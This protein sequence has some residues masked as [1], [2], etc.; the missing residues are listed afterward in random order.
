MRPE[1]PSRVLGIRVRHIRAAAVL[2][3]LATFAALTFAP[4]PL[5]DTTFGGAGSGAGEMSRPEGIAVDRSNGRLYVADRNNRRVDV[6]NASGSFIMAFGWGVADGGSKLETCTTTCLAGLSGGGAGEFSEPSGIAVDNESTSSSYHDVYV[7]DR[8]RVQK[9]SPGGEFLLAFGG[10]VISAGAAGTGDL[11]SGS[12]EVTSVANTSHRFEAGQ[13]ITGTGIPASTTVVAVSAGELTL[14]RPATAS[15]TGATMTVAEGAGNVPVNERQTVNV[16]NPSGMG[17][18]FEA[19]STS[20]FIYENT[21]ASG[22]ASIQSELEGLSN[23]GPGNV[24]VTGPV[25]GPYSIEF[26]GALADTNVGQLTVYG[27]G[28]AGEET[29]VNGHSEPGVCAIAANCSAGVA[30]DGQPGSFAEE[31]PI[32]VAGAA[33]TVYVADSTPEATESQQ[34]YKAR[35]EE[36]ESDGDFLGQ[37]GPLSP[38]RLKNLAVAPSGDFYV[39]GLG[40]RGVQEY[41]ASGHLLAELGPGEQLTLDAAGNLYVNTSEEDFPAIAEFDSSGSTLTRFGY[42]VLGFPSGGLAAYHNAN[43]D[44][45]V[46]LN[47]QEPEVQQLALP[48][49]GP[50]T[51]LSKASSSG[52]LATTAVLHSYVNPEG[53]ATTY[54]FQYVDKHDFEAEGGFASAHT[55]STAESGP[56]GSDFVLHSVSTELTGLDPETVY[57]F[58][59]VAAN[60]AGLTEGTQASFET[61][62]PLVL[63][64]EWATEVSPE[65]AAVHAEVDPVGVDATG[66]FQYVDDATYKESGFADALAAPAV[67]EGATPLDFGSAITMTTAGT[68]LYPLQ[69]DTTYH[70][71]LVASDGFVTEFGPAQT[72]STPGPRA[73]GNEECPNQAL[74]IGPSA[75]LPDCRA[76]E[77]VSPV[78]KN[79]GDA[80]DVIDITGFRTRLDESA[81]SGDAFSYTSAR[82]FP[83]SVG[84]PYASQYLA[85]RDPS[86]GWSSQPISPAQS[87]PD[88]RCCYHDFDNEYQAFSPELTDG[89]FLLN[90]EPA[91]ASG[92]VE[93]SLDLYSRNNVTGGYGVVSTPEAGVSPVPVELALQGAEVQGTSSDGETT[94]FTTHEK[95]ATTGTRGLEQLYDYSGG[96]V[97][98]VCVLPSGSAITEPCSAG[99]PSSTGTGEDRENAVADALSTAGTRVYWTDIKG[100]PG[101][102]TLYLRENPSQPQSALSGSRCTE[103]EKA[104][105]VKVSETV[106][107]EPAEFWTASAD[108]SKALFTIGENLYEFDLASKQST[109]IARKALGVAGASEDLA[110]VYFVSTEALGTGAQAGQPNLYMHHES[111]PVKYIATLASRDVSHSGFDDVASAPIY[112]VSRVTPDGRHLVFMSAA[113]LTGYDNLDAVSG[114]PDDEVYSYEAGAATPVCISCDPSGARPVG[115][116]VEEQSS[117]STVWVA[118]AIPGWETQLY[119][120][121][122]LSDDGSRIFFESYGPLV[123]ADTDGTLD[124]YEWEALGAGDCQ[125]GGPSYSSPSGGCVSLISTGESAE[126][127]L[128]LDASPSGNDVF[129]ATGESLVSGDSGLVDVYDARVDGGF[130]VGPVATP[131]EGEACQAPPI[132]PIDATPASLTFF[133]AGNALSVPPAVASKPKSKP[134]TRAQKLARALKACRAKPRR[135]HPACERQARQKYG[136]KGAAAKRHARTRKAS[137]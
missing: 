40:T 63:G 47:G 120:P 114:E 78:E 88:A 91:L 105:T 109:L 110:Y 113:D 73:Q 22:P 98:F 125:S 41:D 134:L 62:P 7:F 124:V 131:C 4:A 84:A 27:S 60:S 94:I 13:M 15:I 118:G 61:L 55:Q 82:S 72:F 129:I 76:Y 136:R 30:G 97:H 90:A 51:V 1:T 74:R 29:V 126:D 23:I 42:G 117:G 133:G 24:A 86:T 66:Y 37:V 14:S 102:G 122:A 19:R 116:L 36:F 119:A 111:E 59:V 137:A 135:R 6:F 85:R 112:R 70:Y 103:S 123:P 127:S 49:A 11:T 26:K 132:A 33:G 34:S 128:F 77:M 31:D 107:S 71:R 89:W 46:T 18:S 99:T 3:T 106:S 75:N 65:A 48:P 93:G 52:V 64:N 53:H 54:H 56:T 68:E 5:A 45:F 28:G 108:G 95:L 96:A 104:C 58:R 2:G 57:Y 79:N 21:P 67:G 87:P 100:S 39:D 92:G 83:G 130:P 44:V 32:A 17:L 35:L 9:F 50:V 43:G 69:T 12:T 80:I 81:L 8:A 101:A 10:G 38:E 25:G 16:E 121:R 115:R 20:G